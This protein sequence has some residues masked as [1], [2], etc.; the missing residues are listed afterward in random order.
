MA[1]ST[2]TTAL[3][4]EGD[5]LYEV[6]NGQI[7]E[8]EPMGAYEVWIAS[9]LH[10]SVHSFSRRHKLGRAVSEML[11]DLKLAVSRKRRPDVAFVS[12]D[13][14]PSDR[15]VPRTEAWEVVPN[16]AVEIISPTNPADDVV[17]KV[18]EY[19]QAGVEMVWI[20]F[21]SQHQVYAY[22]SPTDVRIIPRGGQLSGDPVLPG[23]VLSLA[24]LFEERETDRT[25]SEVPGGQ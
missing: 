14:W 7:V 18:A 8:Q 2:P 13:R 16:L 5:V 10:A 12:Y 21:P 9:V 19:F 15:Q 20:I 6:V 23:F 1:T 4:I 17:D 11:F 22:T 24:D 25:P 3:P